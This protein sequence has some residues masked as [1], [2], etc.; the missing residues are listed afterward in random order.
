MLKLLDK[1][2][3]NRLQDIGVSKSFLNRKNF[4]S[5][6]TSPKDQQMGQHEIKVSAQQRKIS[7]EAHRQPIEWEKSFANYI[8]DNLEFINL[9]IIQCKGDKTVNQQIQ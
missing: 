2:I 5:T 9:K 3:W 4:N 8:S 7:G 6:G 1:S